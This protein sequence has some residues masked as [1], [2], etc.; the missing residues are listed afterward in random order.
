LDLSRDDEAAGMVVIEHKIEGEEEKDYLKIENEKK[1]F[2][3]FKDGDLSSSGM[4]V[5]LSA[6]K[7]S[8]SS[9]RYS[10]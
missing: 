3:L 4:S 6:K 10:S 1:Q 8:S 7:E 5:N 9:L 2:S